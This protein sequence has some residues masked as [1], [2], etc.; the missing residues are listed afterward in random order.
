MDFSKLKG[1]VPVKKAN[2]NRDSTNRT[3]SKTSNM[4][5]HAIKCEVFFYDNK[6][7]GIVDNERYPI[8]ITD[9]DYQKATFAFSTPDNKHWD[10]FT[11][12]PFSAAGADI[13]NLKKYWQ[14]IVPKMKIWITLENG[15]GKLDMERI[16]NRNEKVFKRLSPKYYASR[17]N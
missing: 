10:W 1:L 3:R 16:N 11:I 12:R 4:T 6:F 2:I 15:V 8:D 17:R 5:P 7:Y 13:E 9:E 14:L